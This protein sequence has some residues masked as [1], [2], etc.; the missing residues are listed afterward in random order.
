MKKNPLLY[1][2]LLVFLTMCK[3]TPPAVTVIPENNITTDEKVENKIYIDNSNKKYDELF[4]NEKYIVFE[5]SLF[6]EAAGLWYTDG[7][8]L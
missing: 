5:E 3:K 8:S 2:I 7:F 1:I 6:S 4:V